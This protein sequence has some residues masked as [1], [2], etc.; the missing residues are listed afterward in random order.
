[1]R[2]L[3]RPETERLFT[4]LLVAAFLSAAFVSHGTAQSPIPTLEQRKQEV[5]EKCRKIAGFLEENQLDALL[6]GLQRDFSWLTA[7]GVSHVVLAAEDGVGALLI[8]KNERFVLCAEDEK[9]RLMQEEHLAD[10]GFSAVS[11]PWYPRPGRGETPL[12]HALSLKAANLKVASD[13]Q[14]PGATEMA[15]KISSLRLQL[16]P[17]E[18]ERYKWLCL[19]TTEI[20]ESVCRAVR[21]GMTEAQITARVS[22]ALLRE[23]I[24]PTVLLIATDDRIVKFR[25]AISRDGKLRKFLQVNLCTRKWGLVC[26]VTR[27]VHF[28]PLPEELRKYQ[29][30]T[31]KVYAA[32]LHATRPGAALGGVFSEIQ[33][34]YA[35]EGFPDE[36]KNHHQG[37]TIG[38]KERETVA[39][40]GDPTVILPGQ[41]VAWNP[42]LP[43]AKC[44]DTVLVLESGNVTLTK[45]RAWPTKKIVIDG[46]AY[47]AP[48]IL[49]R[50]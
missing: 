41:A 23:D 40:P 6:L 29:D 32:A 14:I 28:G 10:F 37:G 33:E 43:G 18:Q 16:T 25:H 20:A 45:T 35:A 5:D 42:T 24:Y 27:L 31:A 4:A 36:W 13:M 34:A 39:T 17:A 48:E 49:I 50:R 47:E 30:V 1:M 11:V 22:Q 8:T 46:K 9:D 3:F 44:E 21:P 15:A 26:A 7:G 38:Y 12:A 19:R 2:P